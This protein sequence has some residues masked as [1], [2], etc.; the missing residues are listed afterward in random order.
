M[1][2]VVADRYGPPESVEIQEIAK[3]EVGDDGVLV[4]VHASSINRGDWAVLMGKPYLAKPAMGL[5]RPK[6]RVAGGDFAGTVEAVGNGVTGIQPGDAVFGAKRGSFAEYV[7]APQRGVALKPSNLTFEEAAALPVAGLTALQGLRDHGQL[8]S[9][10][11][12]LINGASGGVGTFAVQIAKAL[13]GDLTAVCST[14][15]VD[16]A[17]SFGADRVIDYKQSDF[18]RSG[19]RH[20][21]ML[22]IAGG[23]SWSECARVLDPRATVVIIGGPH[24]N[25]WLGA[26]GHA[27]RMRA[28]GILRRRKVIFYIAKI[29]RPG[30]ELLRDL[31]ETGEVR[32][33]VDSRYDFEDIGSALRD[34]G[35]GHIRGKIVIT[36]GGARSDATAA[37]ESV[38]SRRARAGMVLGSTV[39]DGGQRMTQSRPHLRRGQQG[40]ACG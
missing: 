34:M 1:K 24:G 5:R 7:C 25:P 23:R 29:N 6:F 17:R 35:E 36:I 9:G 2:A 11:R 3:P 14:R 21:L 15:N 26:L 10:M 32:P 31:A 8:R 39:G 37:G 28:A 19:L 18:T 12:V 33:V 16:L 22:D 4:R 30:L 38:M 27:L 20:D 13:G 40:S